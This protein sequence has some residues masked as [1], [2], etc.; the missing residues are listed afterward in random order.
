MWTHVLIERGINTSQNSLGVF[1][2][3]IMIIRVW[4]GLKTVCI[5]CVCVGGGL[6]NRK[7]GGCK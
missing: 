3:K 4:K 7:N 5:V 6:I 2:D 1:L